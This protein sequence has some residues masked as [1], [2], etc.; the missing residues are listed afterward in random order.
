MKAYKPARVIE[1]AMKY[2]KSVTWTAAP[3]VETEEDGDRKELMRIKRIA[4]LNLWMR[5][6]RRAPK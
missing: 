2:V 4:E 6:S 5:R 3:H 1:R